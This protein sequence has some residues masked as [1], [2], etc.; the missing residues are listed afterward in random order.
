MCP[1][2]QFTSAVGK[3]HS[4]LL[5][6]FF[7]F[8][9]KQSAYK[10]KISHEIRRHGAPLIE[11]DHDAVKITVPGLTDVQNLF[12]VVGQGAACR[13]VG[14]IVYYRLEADFL[15]V[16]HIA[17]HED[18]AMG[19]PHIGSGVAIALLRE[20]AGIATRIKGIK[21]VGLPYRGERLSVAELKRYVEG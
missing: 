11:E 6:E 9:Q 8:N 3:Q 20:V 4:E 12:A 1:T 13:P 17:A 21:A 5:K 15:D 18:W 16:I 10:G 19:S 14:A 2:Y 7:Y